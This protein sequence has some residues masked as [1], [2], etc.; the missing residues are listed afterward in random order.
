MD[1]F[2]SSIHETLNPAHTA[3]VVVDMQNDFCAENG[4]MHKHLGVD[5]GSN[6]SLAQRIMGLVGAARKAHAM[7]VWIKANYEPRY[8]SGQALAKRQ[9][10]Q[11]SSI[12]CEGGTWGW[13][14]FEVEAEPD[15]WVIEKHTYSGF[16][17]TELDRIL[18]FKGI[19]TLVMTG[20]STNVCVE[21]TLR[22]GY[23]NGYYIVMP[24]DCVD[25]K[26]RNLHDATLMNVR[27]YFGDV[28]GTGAEIAEIWA[29]DSRSTASL[30]T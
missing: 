26:E 23:F 2:L 13:D 29:V 18:R 1:K 7:V 10:K 22:D 30:S 3:V 20:V 5:M 15:E 24:E 25:A 28:V 11:I 27:M 6:F 9:Q 12:C 21:S 4:Y 14:F 16:H 17:G 19:R 8:L